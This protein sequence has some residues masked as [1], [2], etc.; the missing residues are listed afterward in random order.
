MSPKTIMNMKGFFSFFF[1]FSRVALSKK[2]CLVMSAMSKTQ[3]TTS[4]ENCT[5][6]DIEFSTMTVVFVNTSLPALFL[7][8]RSLRSFALFLLI[9]RAGRRNSECPSHVT[10]DVVQNSQ[11]F[12][13][14][15]RRLVVVRSV[16]VSQSYNG[17]LF[18]SS[19]YN[20]SAYVM[21]LT[22]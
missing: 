16:I 10:E 6:S 14:A 9:E 15:T 17:G 13:R 7:L 2:Y 1:F 5:F 19:N 22:A 3:Q 21:L 20:M 11:K 12:C 8:C 18:D 4:F